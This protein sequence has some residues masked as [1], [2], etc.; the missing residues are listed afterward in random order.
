MYLIPGINKEDHDNYVLYF[1]ENISDELKQE[2]RNRLATICYG[3]EQTQSNCGIYS[4][5]ETVKDFIHRYKTQ[6]DKSE[7]RKKGMIGELLA[8]IILELEGKYSTASP[9]FNMEESSFK[10]GFDI[11]LFEEDSKELWITETK[12]GEI[13]KKQKNANSAVSGLI[14]TAKKDLKK[15]LNSNEK[16]LWLN[17]LN[18]ARIYMSNSDHQ[19][20]VVLQL[21]GEISNNVVK[22][23]TSSNQ[24]NVV[25][26]SVLFHPLSD[27][28]ENKAIEKKYSDVV[29]E[30]LFNK[31]FI[32]A[33]QKNTYTAVYN[34]L[35]SEIQNEL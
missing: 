28:M 5:E 11:V 3:V 18:A 1:I 26:S 17:A 27:S 4:Y 8:H 34:F 7:S 12:S 33:I 24:F 10:K 31:T 13:Q 29:K 15:R 16:K 20:Q 32:I 21:L 22:Q 30:K 25:L 23:T 2:I 6:K 19:K 9:F 35:E 14:N